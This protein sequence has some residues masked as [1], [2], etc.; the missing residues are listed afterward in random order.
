MGDYR[1]C[2]AYTGAELGVRPFG[3]P[4]HLSQSFVQV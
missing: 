2:M 1:V 4:V 3:N